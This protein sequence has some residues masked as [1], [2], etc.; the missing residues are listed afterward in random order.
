MTIKY[1]LHRLQWGKATWSSKYLMNASG[2]GT[3]HGLER[4]N[5]IAL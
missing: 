3:K 2:K 4:I 1:T 5:Y